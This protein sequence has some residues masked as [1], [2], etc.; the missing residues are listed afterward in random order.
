ML[1]NVTPELSRK[2]ETFIAA[3][4]TLPTIEAAAAAAQVTGKTAH[5]W[6]KLPHVQEAYQQ[7]RREAFEE[8]LHSLMDLTGEAVAT[9]KALMCSAETPHAVR[10]RAVQIALEQSITVHKLD[11]VLSSVAALGKRLDDDANR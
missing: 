10:I 6:L 4:L 2:Q 8:S 7:A 9:L 5:A 1:E 3:L 11:D